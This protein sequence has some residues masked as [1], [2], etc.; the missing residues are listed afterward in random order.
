MIL[1]WSLRTV[2]N[3]T[4][5][6]NKAEVRKLNFFVKYRITKKPPALF[7]EATIYKKGNFNEL[8]IRLPVAQIKTK[9][10]AYGRSHRIINISEV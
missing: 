8:M 4:A 9:Y 5:D 1:A 3:I 2:Y 7:A 6:K 10:K